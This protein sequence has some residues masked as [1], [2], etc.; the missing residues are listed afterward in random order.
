MVPPPVAE[1]LTGRRSPA[2]LILAGIVF[3]LPII[4]FAL[5]YIYPLGSILRLGL[6]PEGVLDTAALTQL[7]TDG[8]L[9]RVLWFTTWQAMVLTVLTLL[10]AFPGAYVLARYRFRGK[11]AVRTLPTSKRKLVKNSTSSPLPQ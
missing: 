5:F 4:F 2:R 11:T 3:L 1:S 9:L 8:Y 6:I 7:F 10:L